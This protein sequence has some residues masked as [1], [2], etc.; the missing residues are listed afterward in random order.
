M[1]RMFLLQHTNMVQPHHLLSL[2][3]LYLFVSSSQTEN[4]SPLFTTYRRI[5]AMQLGL[6]K[7]V[8]VPFALAEKVHSL[9]PILK[10]MA[11]HGNLACKSDIQV[12]Y[13]MCFMSTQLGDWSS[14]HVFN[15][16]VSLIFSELLKWHL[17]HGN[18]TKLWLKKKP[19]KVNTNYNKNRSI[20]YFI[21]WLLSPDNS[22][23]KYEKRKKYKTHILTK[24]QSIIRLQ[25]HANNC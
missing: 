8:G 21:A 1:L 16:A 9:W 10:E 24:M 3:I 25:R 19:L 14:L 2:D 4:I 13:C 11:Q 17:A 12:Q 23:T 5:T 18:K 7:A 20:W 22:C 15:R 6:K